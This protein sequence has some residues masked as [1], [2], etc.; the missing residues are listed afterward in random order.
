[1]TATVNQR[2]IAPVILSD[3]VNPAPRINHGA[4]AAVIVCGW[5]LASCRWAD[6][7]HVWALAS[8]ALANVMLARPIA[9]RGLFRRACLAPVQIAAVLVVLF[10]ADRALAGWEERG[11]R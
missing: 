7:Q 1:M 4:V 6:P 5:I 3:Q 8:T 11:P 10:S 9:R 2:R